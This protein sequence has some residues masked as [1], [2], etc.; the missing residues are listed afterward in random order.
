M[1]ASLATS[2]GCSPP[3]LAVA[4]SLTGG[5]LASSFVDVAGASAFFKGGLVLYSAEAKIKFLGMDPNL[6]IKSHGV[7]A[8]IAIRMA[9]VAAETFR[10]EF[11][12][13]TTGFAETF[14]GND[15]I[16]YI[17][18]WSKHMIWHEV[19]IS[20]GRT[21][22]RNEFRDLVIAKARQGYKDYFP[23]AKVPEAPLSST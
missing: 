1:A 16:A 10:A 2:L 9:K 6:I 23:T 12:I 7:R 14:D 17:G 8:D 22:S 19:V 13:G 3:S 11:G 5:L 18:Y 15:Q 4:E 21:L 20:L